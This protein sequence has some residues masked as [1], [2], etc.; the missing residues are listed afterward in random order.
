MFF[1]PDL[2]RLVN[3]FWPDLNRVVTNFDQSGLS[4]VSQKCTGGGSYE[5]LPWACVCP[6]PSQ[7]ERGSVTGGS[8]RD[9]EWEG[10]GLAL[11]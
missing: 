9:R 10:S 4:I 11:G 5:G 1:W 2:N 8:A 6:D 7:G 3:I